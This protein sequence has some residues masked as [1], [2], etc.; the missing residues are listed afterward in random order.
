LRLKPED[1]GIISPYRKQVEK[2][3]QLI[4][5]GKKEIPNIENITVGSVEEFQGSE[6]RAIIISTVRSSREYLEFDYS[7]NL[8]FLKNPERF[9]VAITRAQ[10]KYENV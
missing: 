5:S 7:H 4:K 6:R 3:R 8:G 10:V 2:I 9:N 1:I